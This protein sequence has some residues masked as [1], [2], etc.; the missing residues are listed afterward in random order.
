MQGRLCSM[1][2]TYLNHMGIQTWHLR[3][4]AQTNHFFQVALRDASQKI[5]GLIIADLDD[6]IDCDEQKNLLQKIAE[7]LTTYF[8][9][10]QVDG[11]IEE[12]INYQFAILIG[13]VAKKNSVKTDCIIYSPSLIDLMLSL[14]HK[15][16]LWSDIK[17]LR[18]FFP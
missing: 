9:I 6:S 4:N 13:D 8:S 1:K 15:K 2:N 11:I 7:A 10:T 5:I 17:P 18:S 3:D 16:K 14:D 12:S